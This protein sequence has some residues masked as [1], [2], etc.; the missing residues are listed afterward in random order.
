MSEQVIDTALEE[1]SVSRRQLFRMFLGQ[2]TGY[3][4]PYAPPTEVEPVTEVEP[5]IVYEPGSSMPP[6]LEVVQELSRWAN[7]KVNRRPILGGLA[8]FAAG[9]NQAFRTY[10]NQHWEKVPPT[11]TFLNGEVPKN[12]KQIALFLPGFGDIHSEHESEQLAR[13]G[14][15]PPEL[16]IAYF[17]ESLGDATI[18]EKA[19]LVR[20][21][22]N[23]DE[24]ESIVLIG[25][26]MGGEDAWALA[27]ELGVP[28]SKIIMFSSPFS[29]KDGDYGDLGNALKY[30]PNDRELGFVTKIIYSWLQAKDKNGYGDVF[31]NATYAWENA[32]A[33][34]DPLVMEKR[35]KTSLKI[36]LKSRAM[37]KKLEKVIYPGYTK[38]YFTESQDPG[39]DHTVHDRASEEEYKE[40]CQKL[41]GVEFFRIKAPYEGHANVEATAHF[42][43]PILNEPSTPPPKVVLADGPTNK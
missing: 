2:R 6:S 25:R 41:G 29:L 33:G 1:N 21:T 20:A 24:L 5:P 37:I 19:D 34:D 30:A 3:Y 43:M 42:L 14:Q 12:P 32:L 4:E 39:T 35:A 13:G 38:V 31:G 16:P 26:S 17:S 18:E 40:E 27:A 8:L 28:V 36:R 11:L 23:V 9:C 7:I 10:L 22:V 15:L